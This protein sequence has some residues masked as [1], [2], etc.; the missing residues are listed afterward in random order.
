MLTKL[1]I[2][3][4]KQFEDVE[5]E[6]GQ[7]V[8]FI[9]P[10]NSGKTTALQ[11]LTFW[12]IAVTKWLKERKSRDTR[13]GIAVNRL[14]FTSIPVPDADHFW[15][16][17]RYRPG[18]R[19]S[20]RDKNVFI[21]IEVTGITGGA[22]W[23]CDMEAR[24]TNSES[25]SVA[26]IALL[27]KD[28]VRAIEQ[29]RTA[30]LPPMSG[31]TAVEPLLTPG[32][33]DVLI[34]QGRT[35][36]VLRNLCYSIYESNLS[37][38]SQLRA[39]IVS[40]FGVSLRQPLYDAA[41]GELSLRYTT[42]ENAEL[43]ISASGLGM[44]QILLILAYMYTHPNAVILLDEPDAHLEIIRQ[45]EM[46]Q[47]LTRVADHQHSQLIIASHSEII[48]NEAG[49]RDMVVAFV[50]RPHRIDDRSER[51]RVS[52]ALKEIGFDQYFQAEQIG[53]VLYLEGSTDLAIL[54]AF[55]E[56]LD[57]PASALFERLFFKAVGSNQPGQASNH[58]HGLREAKPD[59][60]GIAI[61]D[62]IQPAA[63]DQGL[64]FISWRKREIENYFT[65]PETLIAYASGSGE[66]ENSQRYEDA[67][68]AAINEVEAALA[69]LRKP[70]P[71]SADI[72]ASDDFLD[73]LFVTYFRNLKQPNAMRKTDYHILV[74]YL[75]VEQIDPEVTEK[76]DAILAVAQQAV[77]RGENS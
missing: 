17:L 49:D 10:N 75:P 37:D 54:R 6:L 63:S 22:E 41:R 71:W 56:K 52:K 27:S 44:L 28:T 74:P 21:Q 72:K 53:W 12:Y 32:R 25:M 69:T 64:P 33:V 57:H 62:R 26:P 66:M 47:L 30:F 34:G 70:D 65:T 59:L 42:P 50:G 61:F 19:A 24:Y 73:P 2:R 18:K 39:F 58:F 11:A 68:R 31:M 8:V 36:E 23:V 4:F 43:D 77:P 51:G 16:D 13:M 20:G 46:Y 35:A 55:A 76:L 15:K 7:R 67:M 14:D 48:M 5:I 29:V 1:H 60:V 40:Q 9:G 45:R 3:H 38:W